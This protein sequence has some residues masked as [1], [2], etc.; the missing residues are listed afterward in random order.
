[1]LAPKNPNA[2]QTK[3]S[4]YTNIKRIG[5]NRVLTIRKLGYF[6]FV[7]RQW[8]FSDYSIIYCSVCVVLGNDFYLH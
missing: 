4:R 2:R 1:M 7:L 8:A 5:R 3:V 6:F